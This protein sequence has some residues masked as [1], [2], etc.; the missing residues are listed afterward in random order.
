LKLLSYKPETISPYFKLINYETVKNL[1][2]KG[3]KVI[4]WTLNDERDIKTMID[5]KVDGIISD[6]PNI[7]IQLINV[8]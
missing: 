6:Y 8:R 1:H 3:F 4:P 7:V 2:M 5:F